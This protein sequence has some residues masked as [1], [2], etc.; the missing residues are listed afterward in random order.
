V[1]LSGDESDATVRELMGAGATAYRRKGMAAQ[2]LAESLIQS[3]NARA[4][5][6]HG[7]FR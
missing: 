2:A 7:Q 1:V 4:A 6:R 3:I 5:E